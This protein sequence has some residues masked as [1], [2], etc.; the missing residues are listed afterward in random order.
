M[1]RRCQACCMLC[2]LS[3]R[4]FSVLG[5]C[6]LC[7]CDLLPCLH[8]GYRDTLANSTDGQ[9]AAIA[10]PSVSGFWVNFTRWVT[11]AVRYFSVARLRF[12]AI[13]DTRLCHNLNRI[14]PRT[15]NTR[16]LMYAI[17][18][19]W[20]RPFDAHLGCPE[21]DVN[22]KCLCDRGAPF[23]GTFRKLSSRPSEARYKSK[24]RNIWIRDGV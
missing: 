14:D 6:A 2:P 12:F 9:Y 3:P 20:C 10:D 8:E 13:Y 16:W 21:V 23:G 24:W 11:Q 7:A 22:T 4:F 19:V 5:H 17:V 1:T 15:H 18:L